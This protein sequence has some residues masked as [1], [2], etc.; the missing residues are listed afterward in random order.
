MCGGPTF[1][2]AKIIQENCFFIGF[3]SARKQPE[4]RNDNW[5]EEDFRNVIARLDGRLE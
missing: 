5:D 1:K 4:H 3:Q 2:L